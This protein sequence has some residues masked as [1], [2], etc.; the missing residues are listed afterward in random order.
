MQLVF[1]SFEAFCG[2]QRLQ[3][4]LDADKLFKLS[5]HDTK[6]SKRSSILMRDSCNSPTCAAVIE[7]YFASIFK[8]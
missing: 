4:Q 8:L 1:N 2:S 6:C 5:A 3:R 7:A